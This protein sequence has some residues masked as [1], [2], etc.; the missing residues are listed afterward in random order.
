[1]AASLFVKHMIECLA[2]SVVWDGPVAH[3]F[4][5]LGGVT[6][7]GHSFISYCLVPCE[8]N[9]IILKSS[10]PKYQSRSLGGHEIAGFSWG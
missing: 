7:L 4:H 1:M 6:P 10:H 8:R 2:T 5:L 9:I 3:N